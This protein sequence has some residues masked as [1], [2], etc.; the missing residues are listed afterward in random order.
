MTPDAVEQDLSD[1]ITGGPGAAVGQRDAEWLCRTGGI[2]VDDGSFIHHD[3]SG[4][5]LIR[6]G[7][8]FDKNA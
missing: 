6:N 2:K 5:A 8:V 3:L 1:V 4:G 7:A